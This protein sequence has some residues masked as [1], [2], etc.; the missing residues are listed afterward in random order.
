MNFNRS[1][2]NADTPNV[3]VY[4]LVPNLFLP[5]LHVINK[6]LCKL[7]RLPPTSGEQTEALINAG[8]MSATR[9]AMEKLIATLNANGFSTSHIVGVN[10]YLR[11][12]DHFKTVNQVYHSFFTGGPPASRSCIALN[13][14]PNDVLWIDVIGVNNINQVCHL[15]FVSRSLISCFPGGEQPRLDLFLSYTAPTIPPCVIF[16]SL[17]TGEHRP[18]RSGYRRL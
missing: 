14:P 7:G 18:I 12:M 5:L 3:I 6:T 15:M 11:K 16:V 2:L 17:G 9:S 1:I 8:V 10:I 4:L 13:L